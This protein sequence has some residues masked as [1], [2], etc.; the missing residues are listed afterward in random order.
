MSN[1]KVYATPPYDPRKPDIRELPPPALFGATHRDF[2]STYSAGEM[3]LSISARKRGPPD[4]LDRL[5]CP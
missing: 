5:A 4:K 1:G 2:V 3:G